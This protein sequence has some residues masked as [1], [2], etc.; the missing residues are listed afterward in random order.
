MESTCGDFYNSLCETV[1]ARQMLASGF[2]YYGC[3]YSFSLG[4]NHTS[5]DVSLIIH[6]M[7]VFYL[8]IAE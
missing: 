1:T 6:G 8:S 4:H 3:K 2:H 5:C 7:E